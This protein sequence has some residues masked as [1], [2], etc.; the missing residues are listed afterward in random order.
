MWSR[1]IRLIRVLFLNSAMLSVSDKYDSVNECTQETSEFT[2]LHIQVVWQSAHE[3]EGNWLII[4][5][6]CCIAV[7]HCGVKC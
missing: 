7:L 5:A 2:K 4:L 1:L 3:F 6:Q